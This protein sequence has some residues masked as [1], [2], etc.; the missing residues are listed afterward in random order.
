MELWEQLGKALGSDY[1]V[2][3]EM[4]GGGMSRVFL[5]RDERLGR[6]VVIKVLSSELAATVSVD[7]FEREIMLAAGLQHPHIVP[8]LSAGEADHLP[9]VIMPLVEGESLRERLNRTKTVSVR[10]TVR[11]LKDAARALAYAHARGIVHRDIKPDNILLT[12]GSATLADFGVAK[13]IKSAQRTA[14]PESENSLTRVGTSLGTP[15]YMA[16]EQAAADEAIDHRADIYALGITAY[17]ML[18][19]SPPFSGDSIRELVTAHLTEKPRPIADALTDIPEALAELI[20]ACLEKAPEDRPQDAER[21]VE[22]LEDPAMVSGSVPSMTWA[23]RYTGRRR[24]SL[25]AAIAVVA[26]TG[27]GAWLIGRGWVAADGASSPVP[28]SIGVL[29][30]VNVGGDS[31]DEYFADGMTDELTSALHRVP[32]IRVASRTAAF[33]YKRTQAPLAEIGAALNVA[34]LLEGTVRRAGTRLRLDARLID[35]GDGLALW[36]QRYETELSDVFAVQDSLASA[37]VAALRENF[38]AATGNLEPKRGTTNLQAYDL[39]L[40]GRYFFEKRG[41]EALSTALEYFQQAVD[42]DPSYAAAYTGIADVYALFPLY[43]VRSGD[44]VRPLALRAVDRAISLDSTLANAYASRGNLL[45]SGWRWSEAEVDFRRAVLLDPKNASAYQ[46]YGENL[47]V[48]GRVEEAV[49]QLDR[50][51]ELDPLSPVIGASSAVAL[52][53]AGRF[54]EA[55]GRGRRAVE[56]DPDLAVTRF[57]LGAVFL[58]AGQYDSAIGEL[59]T[60][61]DLSG[62]LAVVKGLLGYSY[63][64]VGRRDEALAMQESI[65]ASTAGSSGPSAVA[66]IHIGLGNTEEALEWLEQAVDLRDPFFSSE[67]MASPVFD[68]L[69]NRPRFAALL[70]RVNLDVATLTGDVRRR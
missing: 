28:G 43:G 25:A 9:F 59:E 16:P 10:E 38:S 36:S 53:V 30:L 34:T 32:G 18:T 17:E 49:V 31:T 58:Y 48:S 60:A 55:R 26:L 4:G 66:R 57:M 67:S 41:G 35:V 20:M 46:W 29:P 42:E 2:E 3:R 22:V 11:V 47:L 68:P 62:G 23:K 8:V 64:A 12:A 63:A 39:Y 5:A 56:L 51:V 27:T 7:R 61:L 37:I 52:G 21:I 1:T 14:T 50:A 69:R 33:A 45:S 54:D 70:R 40:R 44:S 6:K 19:G 24:I 65:E 15:L 13:A